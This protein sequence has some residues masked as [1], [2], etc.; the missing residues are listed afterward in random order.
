MKKVI[1]LLVVAAITMAT[2]SW[3]NYHW[4]SDTL[5]PA[6]KDR[7]K[8]SLYDVSAGVVEW[9]NLG[10]PIQPVNSGGKGQIVVKEASNVFWL[11]LARIF[12]DAD[13]H[14]SKGE[15]LLNTRLLESYGPEAADHV[16]CQELGHVLGLNH[17]RDALDSCMND[18]A[19][20]GSVTTPNA[21]DTE[22]L[23]VIYNHADTV[24]EDDGGNNGKGGGK[25]KPA[26]GRWVT[27]HVFEAPN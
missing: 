16:L 11:G 13:G 26:E 6:V 21:H 3:N 24:E 4:K 14:I 10:T 9:A 17:Q 8:S 1:I 18:Q 19:P 25:G 22:Q 20:L 5:N 2:H 15:V 12:I 7:T 23:L 27:V